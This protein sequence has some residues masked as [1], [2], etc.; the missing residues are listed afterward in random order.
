MSSQVVFDY[1]NEILTHITGAYGSLMYMGPN[2][3]KSLT[4]H[5][6][7]GKYGPFGEEQGQAFTSN[8]REGKIVGFQGKEGLFVDAIGVLVIQGKVP[9]Y[10]VS[11]PS[12]NKKN[13]EDVAETDH[14]Q[15]TNK[16]GLPRRGPTQE[17]LLL[18]YN[19]MD[20]LEVNPCQEL[21]LSCKFR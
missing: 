7:K 9:P 18:Q 11:Q 12:S 16:L 10:V 15:L 14:G 19:D 13:E 8:I 4:F 1:P 20:W 17:V 6:N 3:I 2:I 21:K 5:T